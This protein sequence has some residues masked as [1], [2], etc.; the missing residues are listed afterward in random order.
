MPRINQNAFHEI[1]EGYR[2]SFIT[3]QI[4]LSLILVAV[5]SLFGAAYVTMMP[6]ITGTRPAAASTAAASRS[7][8][9][10]ASSA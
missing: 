3:P 1:F 5:S 8:S 4:R 10:P 2:Y 6:A 7:R 9:S